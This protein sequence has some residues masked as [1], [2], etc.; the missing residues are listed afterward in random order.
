MIINEAY[1][2]GLLAKLSNKFDANLIRFH[3]L[4]RTTRYRSGKQTSARKCGPYTY[5]K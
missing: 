4:T 2:V 3:A 5:W 1:F